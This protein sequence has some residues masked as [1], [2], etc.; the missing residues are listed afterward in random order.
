ML[1]HV[2]ATEGLKREHVKLNSL[3][4][5]VYIVTGLLGQV[6]AI[7][8]GNVTPVWLP[9]GLMFAFALRFGS[10]VWPGIFL[11]AFLGNIW[12]YFSV[13]SLQQS[14]FAI[15][16]AT[17]N[18]IGDVLAV[19][20]IVLNLQKYLAGE[21]AFSSIYNFSKFVFWGVI[22][23]SLISALCGVTGLLLFGFLHYEDYWFSIVNWWIGDGVGVLLLCPLLYTFLEEHKFKKRQFSFLCMIISLL[24]FSSLSLHMFE[25]INIPSP[26][27]E[28]LL[29]TIPAFF[30]LILYA[31]QRAVYITQIAVVAIAIVATHSGK[32]PFTTYELFTPLMALQVFIAIFSMVVFSIALLLDDKRRMLEQLSSQ[33]AQLESLY[34]RDP[35]TGLWNRYRIEEFLA[36]DLD[37]FARK[38]E[39]FAVLMIDI[40]DFKKVNDT[41]GH[42][43]GDRVLV[44][45]SRL[46]SANTRAGDLV[47]RWGGEEFILLAA[48][49]EHKPA[50]QFANKIVALVNEHDFQLKSSLSISIGFTLCREGD[51]ANSLVDRADKGLYFAKSHG[52]NQAACV[53]LPKK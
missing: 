44:E 5:V 22:T 24:I 4:A 46:L 19:V 34:N 7:P 1:G 20:W 8:P 18:G 35:L 17:F 16:A 21:S 28:L 26:L 53:D 51:N 9:S 12:A 40:D 32:G 10:V 15:A 43:E 6:F 47:G 3:I 36:V 31:G 2:F 33:N 48:E 14:V 27:L 30:S 49:P 41:Y 52:K 13:S 39:S 45:I 23:G 29:I 25:L 42:L 11:G 38:Q 50:E 37:R